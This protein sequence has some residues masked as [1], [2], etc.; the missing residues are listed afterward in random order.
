MPKDEQYEQRAVDTTAISAWDPQVLSE[1]VDTAARRNRVMDNVIAETHDRTDDAGSTFE[2]RE[3]GTLDVQ[4]QSEGS[5]IS[6]EDLSYSTTEISV[7]K[8]GESVEITTEADEDGLDARQEDVA[9]ELGEAFAD[10][11]DQT[12]Y[13]TLI[14]NASVPTTQLNSAGSF[15]EDEI[16]D[17]RST[18]RENNYNPDS[19]VVHPSLEAE[20][21]KI[22]SFVRADEYGSDTPV[23]TGELGRIFGLRVFVSTTA[24]AKGTTG[25]SGTVQLAAVDSER[26]LHRLVKRNI[27]TEIEREERNDQDV[28]VGT[29]RWGHSVVNPNA[30]AFLVN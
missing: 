1:M 4:T 11:Q 6:T 15:T 24:N 28:V 16:I 5:Q 17:I 18:V 12:A 2:V 25:S 21:L 3:R 8:Y 9:V 7:S 26:C 30:A 23:R 20:L 22:N 19:I 29:A 14:G 13:D 10:S 27:T